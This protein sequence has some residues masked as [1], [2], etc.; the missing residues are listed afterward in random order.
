MGRCSTTR[1]IP[2]RGRDVTGLCRV[3]C[4]PYVRRDDSERGLSKDSALLA[5]DADLAKAPANAREQRVADLAIGGKLLLAT[6]FGGGRIGR[7]PI[8]HVGG[9]RPGQVEGLVMRLRRQRDD[10]I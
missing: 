9:E 2:L 4:R 5:C 1:R 6:A 8:F 7:R 3:E 10:E